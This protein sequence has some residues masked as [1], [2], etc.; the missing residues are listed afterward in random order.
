LQKLAIK[1]RVYKFLSLH[2]IVKGEETTLVVTGILVTMAIFV[3]ILLR[4]VF[5]SPLF[6]IEELTLIVVSWFYFIGAS[7]SVHEG[8]YIMADILPLVVK[9]Q[10][11]LQRFKVACLLL[12]MVGAA[13]LCYVAVEYCHWAAGAHAVTPTFMLSTNYA[14]ASV[15]VGGGLMVMH[16]VIRMMREVRDLR[17]DKA[18]EKKP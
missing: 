12:G 13:I 15:V 14:T 4:Y 16:F 6:G 1:R 5:H 18:M 10:L 17:P 2:T 8:S 9:N 7:Y 3:Q 11:L